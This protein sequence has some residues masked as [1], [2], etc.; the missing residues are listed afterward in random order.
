[1]NRLLLIA[2]LA[3]VA[4]F[5][6]APDLHPSDGREATASHDVSQAGQGDSD[7]VLE[8]AF[9]HRI[10]NL[11][12]AGQGTVVKLLPDDASG[13]RHQR[14]ILRLASGRTLLVAHNID[15]AARIETLQAGDTVAFYGEYEWNPKGGV[16]HWTHHDP[17]ARHVSGWIKHG[18]QVYQ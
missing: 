14:F 2:A 15:L 9:T 6:F 17:Q 10:G 12:V 5:T 11:Q 1:M 3:V 8:H 18:G 4:Y 16:I 7:A 13:S